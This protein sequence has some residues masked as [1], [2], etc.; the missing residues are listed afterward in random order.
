[1]FLDE[2]INRYFL[3]CPL[4]DKEKSL[5][6]QI[7]SGVIRWKGYLD[8]VLSLYAT[9]KIRRDVRHL[10]WISLYQLA[11]M[12]KADFH[13]VNETVEY[14]KS[15]VGRGQANFVNAVLRRFLREKS[16]STLSPEANAARA[17]PHW[18]VNR[19]QKRFGETELK[20]LLR[21]LNDIPKFGLRVNLSKISPSE[22]ANRLTMEGIET[23]PGKL[24]DSS[25]TVDKLG[26]VLKSGMFLE[27]LIHVQDEMSQLVGA[28]IGP[29][30]AGTFI[31]D[32]CAGLGT[33]TGQ[34][35]ELCRN[36]TI[37][38]MDNEIR[39]LRSLANSHTRVAANA[40]SAP[41]RKDAFD[42]ILVDA[43]CSSLGILRKHP[44]IKWRRR[45]RDIHSFA[46]IQLELVDRLWDNLKR[47]GFMIYS[48]C[49]FEPEE[50][51]SVIEQFRKKRQFV[52]ENP[53][54][55]RFNR[56]YFLS[57]PHETGADG[58]FI[59]KMRKT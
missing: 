32:A 8:W 52:L 28:A 55:F 23:S 31:L 29:Q 27:G 3:D 45:E 15:E 1:M 42:V 48:V 40:V 54:P 20:K 51:V 50:T 10:I 36:S 49:S 16:E 18:L 43:P 2:T 41:F 38:C 17:F 5:I 37:V 14:A 35:M 58:F 34:L 30:H 39:K 6:Y 25:L 59:A 24:M 12:R 44:E 19:W 57:L 56:E 4:S 11:F 47:G 53:L 9:S 26:P 33:K 46:A 7:T 13:V 22:A 21:S